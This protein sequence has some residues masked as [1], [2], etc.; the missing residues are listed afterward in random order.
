MAFDI[1]SQQPSTVLLCG[2][3][4][5]G[6]GVYG[7]FLL[8]HPELARVVAV[9]DPRHE[10]RL[11]VVEQHQLPAENAFAD[12][13]EV[14]TTHRIADI[15]VVATP[16]QQHLEPALG[17][18]K[19]G[20]HLLLEKPMA[21]TI[22]DCRRIVEA[23]RVSTTCSAVCHV[24]RYSAYFRA[25]RRMIADGAVGRPMT[26]RTHGARQFLALRA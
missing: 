11:K 14:P 6:Q 10:R 17:F 25:L 19:S 7:Q 20:Y 26:L 4:S 23:S 24:L 22:E 8:R 18:L 21:A 2:A 13:K 12:W 1:P 3:G 15:A 5:R 16:D 9:V